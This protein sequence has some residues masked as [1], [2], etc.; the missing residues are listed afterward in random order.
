[1]RLARLCC[2]GR[3]HVARQ[4]S[5]VVRRPSPASG[6]AGATGFGPRA[7]AQMRGARRSREP[8]ARRCLPTAAPTGRGC[9]GWPCHRPTTTTASGIRLRIRRTKYL[10][11]ETP[12][13]SSRMDRQHSRVAVRSTGFDAPSTMLDS[14]RARKPASAKAWTAMAAARSS[15]WPRARDADDVER[16]EAGFL[17]ALGG[18]RRIHGAWLARGEAGQH[19]LDLGVDPFETLEREIVAHQVA[20]GQGEAGKCHRIVV[21]GQRGRRDLPPGPGHQRDRVAL[22]GPLI[23]GLRRLERRFVA[24]DDVDEGQGLDVTADDDQAN[25]Q[26]GRDQQ[27]DR[28]PQQRPEGGRDDDRQGGQSGAVT[29][30]QGLDELP[31]HEFRAHEQREHHDGP[32]T[33]RERWRPR[34]AAGVRAR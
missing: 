32:A 13:P 24:Q 4:S 33:S 9:R 20:L 18:G 10:M 11:P 31:H 8:G 28:S 15:S 12:L 17:A 34:G 5:S 22:E 29:V 6:T 16:V 26:R 23:E 25:G 7:S 14:S 30:D 21:F 19:R 27:A 3:R 2:P 1:M